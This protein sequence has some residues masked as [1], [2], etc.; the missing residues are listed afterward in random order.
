MRKPMEKGLA[1]MNT[2]RSCS[3]SKVS[4]ELWPSAS[5]TWSAR[6]SLLC[7]GGLVQ[8]GEAAQVAVFDQE[9]GDAL[10]EADLATH[11]DDLLA[12]VLHHLHQLEGADV[13]VRDVEDFLRARR[14]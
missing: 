3:I 4:R 13:R 1:S 7:A 5:T 6:S 11:G 8:H 12:H 10:L 9:V 14:P 2:P